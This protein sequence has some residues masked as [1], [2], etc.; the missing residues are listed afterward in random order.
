MIPD[1]CF[2]TQGRYSL[3]SAFEPSSSTQKYKAFQHIPLLD[4]SFY[5]FFFLWTLIVIKI[6]LIFK[7]RLFNQVQ[8]FFPLL[9]T[10]LMQPSFL[11]LASFYLYLNYD[12]LPALVTFSFFCNL[13]SLHSSPS[14]WNLPSW[15]S[16]GSRKLFSRSLLLFLGTVSVFI[17]SASRPTKKE[18]AASW[19][20]WPLC[21]PLWMFRK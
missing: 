13:L 17:F 2:L 18:N 1:L 12:C 14:L 16:G 20:L 3:E 5:D 4:F 6:W 15:Q 21:F 8:Y 10:F 7:E 11:M 9:C 19:L